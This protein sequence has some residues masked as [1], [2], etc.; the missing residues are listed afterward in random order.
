MKSHLIGILLSVWIA[1]SP[2]LYFHSGEREEK[3]IIE[4]I[5]S[6]TLITGSYKLL[7]SK[8]YGPQGTF[9]FTSHLPGEHNIC[10][11]SNSTKLISFGGSKLRIHLDIRVGEHFLDE[12]IAQAK[13][14]VNEV[15]FRLGHLIEQIHHI[16]KEQNYH[17]EREEYFRLTSEETNSNILWWALAQTLILMLVGI[18]QMKCLKDFFIAKKL[19]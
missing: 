2:A 11:Q 9:S 15:N 3:C 1:V 14:K 17:R 6:D 19:V 7:L 10:L 5:P 12:A 13:D 8:L 4:D 18:W 16:S